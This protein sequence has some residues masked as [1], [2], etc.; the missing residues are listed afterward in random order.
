MS[1]QCV[2]GIDLGTSGT[3]LLLM[4]RSGEI[5]ASAFKPY[6]VIQPRPAWAEQNPTDWT[7]AAVNGTKELLARSH[8]DPG[9][10]VAIGL[11][12]QIDGVVPVDEQ[13]EPLDNAIIWMDRRAKQQCREVKAK[14]SEENFYALTGLAID[15]SHMAPK[16]MW[17]RENR[18]KAYDKAE[19]FLLPGNY[20]L[21]FLT[22]ES[23]TDHSNASCSM[24]YDIKRGQ[25]DSG[26]CDLMG[27]AREKL[28]AIKDSTHVAG[29]ITRRFADACGLRKDVKVVVGGG[30]EEIGAVGAGV[31]DHLA[32]LDLTGTS[33]PMC[34]SLDQPLLDPT[35]LLECHAHGYPGKWLLENTG[36]LSGGIYKW[37]KEQLCVAETQQAEK[38]G[39]S[40]YQVLNQAISEVPAGSE[41]LL[42]L[43]FFSGSILPEWNPDARGV[44]LG[45][46][47]GHT[48]QHIAR[49]MMEGTAYV[50][51]D[52]ME[53]LTEISL[54]PTRIVLAGGG[55]R[56]EI[57]R[58]I[59]TDV[60][61]KRTVCCK[62]EE[63]TASGA[64]I[65][66]L[67]GSGLYRDVGE[68]VR[69]IVTVSNPASPSPETA[70]TYK[71][72]HTIYRET[73]VSL[74]N[75][76]PQ[77]AQLQSGE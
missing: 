60:I 21:K 56:G 76:F 54:E 58:K 22:D 73:Y 30:D 50:L 62:N 44:I 34:L 74:K 31:I 11:S 6:S 4:D 38:L 14:M 25:W 49:A 39:L 35:R 65:L 3:K 23:Y 42:F 61:G 48:R 47:L 5:R 8:I 67:V 40:A 75:I 7:R 72:L 45:L 55:A 9:N 12:S 77:I 43:P 41:G 68:A 33:E 17:L 15:P 46:T 27:I 63:V 70:S 19:Q 26:L 53:H 59:K 1:I 24:L 29:N 20:L 2:I 69:E 51:K 16:I 18:P 32:L 13:E 66:A 10:I 28:P 36:G 71:K 57:W 37:F 52:F 64:A